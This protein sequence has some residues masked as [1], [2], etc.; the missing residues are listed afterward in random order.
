M[1]DTLASLTFL[2]RDRDALFAGLFYQVFR[3]EGLRV[4]KTPVRA[5]R[6][7]AICERWIGSLRRECLDWIFIVHRR[8]LEAIVGEYVDHHNSHRPHRSL[9]L[10]AP[11]AALSPLPGARASPPHI[12]RRDRLGDLLHE[13]EVAA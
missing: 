10:R 11:D 7:N 4:I 3:S 9:G 2:L 6:A 13:Y 8:Q 5:P 1:G 12:R